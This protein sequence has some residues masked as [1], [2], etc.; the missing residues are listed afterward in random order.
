MPVSIERFVAE[1]EKLK[2]EMDAGK[3]K[4][5]E[6]DQRLARI[7]A[8]LR[9]RKVDADRPVITKTLDE[10]LGRGVITPSVKAHVTKR[11]GL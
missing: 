3:L 8:E 1:L 2:A 10:L 5:S 4:H 9:E 7:I 11:L 6:Y